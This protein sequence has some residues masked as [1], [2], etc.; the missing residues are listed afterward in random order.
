M[1]ATSASGIQLQDVVTTS[2]VH[3]S[4]IVQIYYNSSTSYQLWLQTV[5]NILPFGESMFT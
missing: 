3:L 5:K 2:P 4:V 1:H